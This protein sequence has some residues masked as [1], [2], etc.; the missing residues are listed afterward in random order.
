VKSHKPKYYSTYS[1][2]LA[3]WSYLD[4]AIGIDSS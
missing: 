1:R 2:L 3:M 4:Y